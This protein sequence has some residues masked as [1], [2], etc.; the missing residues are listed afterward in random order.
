MNIDANIRPNG[1]GLIWH[2][3]CG[4]CVCVCDVYVCV[5]C[6][7]Y[8][9]CIFKFITD[10]DDNDTWWTKRD[11]IDSLAFGPNELNQILASTHLSKRLFNNILVFFEIQKLAQINCD[12]QL[13]CISCSL[14]LLHI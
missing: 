5:W 9:I 11:C 6:A 2:F 12:G 8:K 1:P 3:V 4:V 13:D 14:V 7:K 10:T